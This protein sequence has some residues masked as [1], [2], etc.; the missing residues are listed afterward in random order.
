MQEMQQSCS[1]CTFIRREMVNLRGFM[2]D[3]FS[4]MLKR[5]DG[6]DQNIQ[7]LIESMQ[8]VNVKL[9]KQ[10]L[11]KEG[12]VQTSQKSNNNKIS[13][14]ESLLRKRLSFPPPVAGNGSFPTFPFS[15][16]TQRVPSQPKRER[17]QMP[18][19][20]QGKTLS[21][22]FFL[23]FLAKLVPFCKNVSNEIENIELIRMLCFE[24]RI[25][26]LIFRRKLPIFLPLWHFFEFFNL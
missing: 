17:L 9:D 1:E 21:P 2:S 15:A 8:T 19:M 11:T 25:A 14:D 23:K 10:Q 3:C 26:H 18:P 24:S 4:T 22:I 13:I 16:T 5:F 20:T 12:T 7:W 6:Q